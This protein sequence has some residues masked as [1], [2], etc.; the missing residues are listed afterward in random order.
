MDK[1]LY[2][3][4]LFQNQNQILTAQIRQGYNDNEAQVMT[5]LVASEGV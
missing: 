1:Q 3:P 2:G 4:C 5:V